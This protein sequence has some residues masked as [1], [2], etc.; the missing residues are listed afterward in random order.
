MKNISILYFVPKINLIIFSIKVKYSFVEKLRNIFKNEKMV[1]YQ[2]DFH[3]VGIYE[4]DSLNFAF[5]S[6]FMRTDLDYLYKVFSSRVLIPSSVF[7]SI[8]YK[9][10]RKRWKL[11]SGLNAVIKKYTGF[12]KQYIYKLQMKNLS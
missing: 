7:F 2:R 11:M 12:Q 1:N 10:S 9:K 5:S 3:G 4:Q 8:L 6:C